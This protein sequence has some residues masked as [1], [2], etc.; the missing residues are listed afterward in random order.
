MPIITKMD[1][2]RQSLRIS[3]LSKDAS[4][5]D[6]EEATIRHIIPAI[7]NE[8]YEQLLTAYKENTTDEDTQ[9]LISL[10]QKPLAAYAFL[11]NI[12]FFQATITDAGIRRF[13]ADNMP[14]VFAWEYREITKALA[15]KAMS[16]METLLTYLEEHATAWPKWQNSKQRSTRNSALIRSGTEFSQ[17]YALLHPL[18]T[19]LALLPIIIEVQDNYLAP[20]IG[21]DF[22]NSL[23]NLITPTTHEIEIL[24]LLKKA[25]SHYTIKHAIERLPVMVS[26]QGL[27]VLQSAGSNDTELP[28]H[29]NAPN[30]LLDVK[31]AAADRDGNMYLQK[32]TTYLNNNASA[33]I[34]PIYYSSSYYSAP[35]NS[36]R[37]RGNGQRRI[38]RF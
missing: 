27:T 4:L 5:P 13:T 23:L 37:D 14:G 16:G 34:F 12:A 6:M 20:T 3:S 18:R 35:G 32:S 26:E 17:N 22:L 36:Q 7:G 28:G 30:G 21:R 29:N 15:Q 25:L 10:V 24:R 33:A 19:F 8:L 38:F 31:K 2:V 11:D 9:K 1:E